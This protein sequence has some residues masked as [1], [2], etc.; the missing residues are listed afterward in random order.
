[1]NR[2]DSNKKINKVVKPQGKS[3]FSMFGKGRDSK[4]DEDIQ[5]IS[6]ISQND[7]GT[8]GSYRDSG[9]DNEDMLSFI[10]DYDNKK[11]N[12]DA[13]NQL[14]NNTSEPVAPQGGNGATQQVFNPMTGMPANDSNIADS[15]S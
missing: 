14:Q 15:F 11:N 8:S 13:T 1:M 3:I 2:K 4:R 5:S 9:F 12:K 6:D 10:K 7:F